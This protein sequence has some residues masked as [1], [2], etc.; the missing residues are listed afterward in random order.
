MQLRRREYASRAQT[1][2]KMNRPIISMGSEKCYPR[3]RFR[4]RVGPRNYLPLP[5]R[6]TIEATLLAL[7]D[8]AADP[9]SGPRF[10]GNSVSPY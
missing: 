3:A 7:L 9:L 2:T 1:S 8:I 4:A 5:T 10:E 6:L